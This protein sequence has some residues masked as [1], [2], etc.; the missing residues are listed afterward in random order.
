MDL[1]SLEK[2]AKAATICNVSG[3]RSDLYGKWVSTIRFISDCQ[4]CSLICDYLE[5]GDQ[6]LKLIAHVR[7]LEYLKEAI[8]HADEIGYFIQ[9]GST[10]SWIKE[11]LKA[12]N[13]SENK[14]KCNN[15]GEIIT[16]TGPAFLQP[17]PSCRLKIREEAEGE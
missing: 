3:I 5:S 6:V 4:P 8:N 10:A 12:C 11:A 17:C 1:D 16:A 13:E 9:G 14:A 2:L 15:C 7:R